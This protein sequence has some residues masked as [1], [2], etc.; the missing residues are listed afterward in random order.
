[1]QRRAIRTMPLLPP[2]MCLPKT[3]SKHRIPSNQSAQRNRRH[4]NL[5]KS[6]HSLSTQMSSNQM[7]RTSESHQRRGS[8]HKKCHRRVASQVISTRQRTQEGTKT[9][10]LVRYSRRSMPLRVLQTAS[11]SSM[12]PLISSEQEVYHR[13]SSRRLLSKAATSLQRK[14]LQQPGLQLRCLV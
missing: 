3:R 4:S 1:M 6:S 2:T 14:G 10:N 12:S 7:V 5:F 13:I 8:F 9:S 11:S